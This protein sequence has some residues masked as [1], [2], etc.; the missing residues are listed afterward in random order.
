ML[1]LRNRFSKIE[2]LLLEETPRRGRD[3]APTSATAQAFKAKDKCVLELMGM[4][5]LVAMGLFARFTA[6]LLILNWNGKPFF[7][8]FIPPISA[9]KLKSYLKRQI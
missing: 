1:F 6:A 9:V 7:A 4:V 2:I 8:I 3:G 5:L